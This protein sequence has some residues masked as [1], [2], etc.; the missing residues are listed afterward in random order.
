MKFNP[1]ILFLL[2]ALAIVLGVVLVP[3]MDN[4]A[5]HHAA[6]ALNMT[7]SGDYVTLTDVMNGHTPY[8]DKPHLQFW[9]VATSFAFFGVSGWVYK[10]SSLLFVVLA[11]FS[12]Y[13]LGERLVPNRGTGTLAALILCSMLAFILGS[14][15][16]IRMDAILTGAVIFAIWQGVICIGQARGGGVRFNIWPYLGLALGMALAFLCKGLFG[17]VIIGTS[18]FFY[19]IGT[20]QLRWVI[21]WRFLIVLGLFAL[22]ILPELWAFYE[23]FGW[24]GV[25][26]I[27]Y[28]QVLVRTG[29]GMGEVSASDPLFFVHTLLWTVLP[30]SA[31][32][33]FFFF[34]SF[35]SGKF[36]S[37]YW[38]TVPGTVV[39]IVLLSFS[40]FKLPHYLNPLFALIALFVA[41]E[42]GQVQVRTRLIRGVAL[43]QKIVVAILVAGI[44]V[45][46]YWLFLF[47]SMALAVLVGLLV[48]WLVYGLC[49]RWENISR[50]VTF[51]VAASAVLWL[52]LNVNFY[53]QLMR[54]Q[55]GNEA[56]DWCKQ[57]NIPEEKVYLYNAGE[58]SASFE[59]GQGRIHQVM[60]HNQILKNTPGEPFYLFVS[61][62]SAQIL[63]NDTLIGARKIYSTGDYHI[64]RLTPKFLNPATRE[65]QLEEVHILKIER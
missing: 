1:T 45:V 64:T 5:A 58:R 34:K 26:F 7:E 43:T 50:V 31:L 2:L 25:R 12:T 14:S 56:S 15:V 52:A 6:I 46:N 39:V 20:K 32:L 33:F 61:D 19:M 4:D 57:N 38:L 24:N 9:L 29:G 55:A 42:L 11:V 30:W 40:A 3:L 44:V 53:P 37:T 22:M 63:L 17:V 59:V 65:S 18:L 27:L 36:S 10:L 51:S 8:L 54:Y 60:S 48:V 28:E 21:S 62:K 16:D 49:T 13:K 35:L 23:Q 41:V 47:E